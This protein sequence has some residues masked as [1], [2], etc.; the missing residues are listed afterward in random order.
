VDTSDDCAANRFS[1]DA[2]RAERR[3]IGDSLGA[4]SVMDACACEGPDSFKV[5]NPKKLN[6]TG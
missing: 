4:I 1:E 5:K 3:R 6:M 2:A